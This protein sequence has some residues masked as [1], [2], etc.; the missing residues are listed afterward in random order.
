MIN[1]QFRIEGRFVGYSTIVNVNGWFPEIQF[2]DSFGASCGLYGLLVACLWL[3]NL[4]DAFPS[5]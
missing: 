3:L 2:T 4:M 1:A 5:T